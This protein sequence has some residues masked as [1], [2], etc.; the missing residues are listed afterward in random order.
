MT[1]VQRGKIRPEIVR[2]VNE[3]LLDVEN[4][5]GAQD[6]AVDLPVNGVLLHA[7]KN[8]SLCY[9]YCIG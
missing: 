6:L 1:V 9:L 8:L 4:D 3:M 5:T 2:A 7:G